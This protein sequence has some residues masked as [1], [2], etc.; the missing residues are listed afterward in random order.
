MDSCWCWSTTPINIWLYFYFKNIQYIFDH[1]LF[2]PATLPRPSP[3]S[4]SFN[5]TLKKLKKKTVKEKLPKQSDTHNWYPF[6][7]G[8]LLLGM[9]PAL[10]C[11]HILFKKTDFP[12][13]RKYQF[14]I[15]SQLGVGVLRFCA[16]LVHAVSFSKL[17][18][19][20]AQLCLGDE[21]SRCFL[22]VIQ[23]LRVLQ[24]FRILFC[25]ALW[26]SRE[27]VSKGY[28]VYVWTLESM[29]IS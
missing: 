28:S 13:P 1:I 9:G 27:G 4:F 6:C 20:S 3:T 10:E 7:A 22:R 26:T 15:T 23:H 21:G 24:S 18:C 17:L 29:T 25:L 16:D 19:V 2:P 5:V 12:F 14:Q 11:T 8:F